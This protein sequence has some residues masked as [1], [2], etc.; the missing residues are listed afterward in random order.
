MTQISWSPVQIACEQALQA[1]LAVGPEKEGELAT[2]SRCKMLIGRDDISY[3]K[4]MT[5]LLLA[6]VFQCLFTFALVS[7]S[8]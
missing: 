1:T 5:S 4:V 2:M 6:R 7:A 8:C 3:T